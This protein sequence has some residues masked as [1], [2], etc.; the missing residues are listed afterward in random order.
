MFFQALTPRNA[1]LLIQP[2]HYLWV[3]KLVDVDSQHGGRQLMMGK[4][5][6]WHVSQVWCAFAKARVSGRF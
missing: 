6:A 2:C 3:Q 4:M 1:W 5:M